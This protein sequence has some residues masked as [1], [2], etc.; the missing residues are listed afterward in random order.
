M[1][2]VEI[3]RIGPLL[4]TKSAKANAGE[5]AWSEMSY[6]RRRLLVIKESKRLFAIAK[7]GAEQALLNELAPAVGAAE[8]GVTANTTTMETCDAKYSD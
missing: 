4:A 1:I 2:R 3:K 5:L 6:N 7:A 8:A